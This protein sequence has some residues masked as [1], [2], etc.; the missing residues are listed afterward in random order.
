[1]A[2]GGNIQ[3][4]VIAHPSGYAEA[5]LDQLKKDRAV[6]LGRWATLEGVWQVKGQPV[7]NAEI[8]LHWAQR[9]TVRPTLDREA[10]RTVTDAQGHFAF[11]QVPQGSFQL[12][13]RFANNPGSALQKVAEV[14]LLPGEAKQVAI[15]EPLTKQG[16]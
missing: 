3:Q 13:T 7:T 6:R 1:V 9:A 12:L 4:A 5:T 2:G 14:E 16:E 8:S 15:Q 10:F 11:P